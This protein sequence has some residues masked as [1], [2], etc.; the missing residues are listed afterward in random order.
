MIR[1]LAIL[2]CTFQCA[3]AHVI[4]MSCIRKWCWMTPCL[5]VYII[6]CT[7][8][9][10]KS[11]AHLAKLMMIEPCYN[12]DGNFNLAQS[13]SRLFFLTDFLRNVDYGLSSRHIR[14]T[15]ALY[16]YA[17]RSIRSFYWPN[18][19]PIKDNVLWIR[20]LLMSYTCNYQSY[21]SWFYIFWGLIRVYL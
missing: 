7:G 21:L 19:I 9:N 3:T 11:T 17:H 2:V 5:V 6:T 8:S 14:K 1:L 16:Q 20:T 12:A 4:L 15:T 18:F 10:C 13:I